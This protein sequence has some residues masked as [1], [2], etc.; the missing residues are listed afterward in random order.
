MKHV[1]NRKEKVF[2]VD[3]TQGI[4]NTVVYFL[5][6]VMMEALVFSKIGDASVLVSLV[7]EMKLLWSLMPV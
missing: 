2:C 7:S 4:E 5:A 3:V 6:V 1:G